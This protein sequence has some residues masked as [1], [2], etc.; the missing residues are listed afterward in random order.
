[1]SNAT[2]RTRWAMSL[3]ATEGRSRGGRCYRFVTSI[4]SPCRSHHPCTWA[5]SADGRESGAPMTVRAEH[6]GF[7]GTSP[8]KGG[9]TMDGPPPHRIDRPRSGRRACWGLPAPSAAPAGACPFISPPAESGTTAGMRVVVTPCRMTEPATGRNSHERY[10]PGNAGAAAADASGYPAGP[11]TA[12]SGD[13]RPAAVV[14]CRAGPPGGAAPGRV[15][16]H[17]QLLVSAGLDHTHPR[18]LRA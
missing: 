7:A 6:L 4:R 17:L 5:L 9:R 12:P 3:M 10:T 2:A 18:N 15:R 14:R 13:A 11:A 16:L 8:P 1:M